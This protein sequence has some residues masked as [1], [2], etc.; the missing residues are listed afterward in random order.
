MVREALRVQATTVR[1]LGAALQ[2]HHS[3]RGTAA[4]RTLTAFYSLL[5]LERCKS[6]A[7]AYGMELLATAK[8]PLPD[9]NKNVDGYE[10]DFSWPTYRLIIE[11]D[12]LQFHRDK[13]LDAHKTVCWSEANWT[14]RRIESDDIF[15]R[16][17]RLLALAPSD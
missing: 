8:R 10:A 5:Q 1:S 7:E 12:G 4:L 11:I 6:D 16:P 13:L 2:K 14:V 15:Q 3:R 9:V 17:H